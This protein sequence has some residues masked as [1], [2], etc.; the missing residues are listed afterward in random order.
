MGE[1][2]LQEDVVQQAERVFE[3]RERYGAG[4]NDPDEVG[5]HTSKE[6]PEAFLLVNLGD[7]LTNTCVRLA[8]ALFL[9]SVVS[10]LRLRALATQHARWT[11]PETSSE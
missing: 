3:R 9:C 2:V 5:A 11:P 7:A 8:G 1:A 10:T 4:R 6:G